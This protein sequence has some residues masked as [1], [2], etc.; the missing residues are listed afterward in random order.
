M[1]EDMARKDIDIAGQ[2]E[3]AVAAEKKAVLWKEKCEAKEA[4]C[5]LP[6]DANLS[7]EHTG[8]VQ[9]EKIARMTKNVKDV[10]AERNKQ[11]QRITDLQK[12][13]AELKKKIKEDNLSRK[14]E[15]ALDE[16]ALKA[17][18]E[19]SDAERKV[20]QE[21]RMSRER[22]Y[23]EDM[24]AKSKEHEEK[25]QENRQEIESLKMYIEDKET[26][27]AVKAADIVNC[28]IGEVDAWEEDFIEKERAFRRERIYFNM[29]L[30]REVELAWSC[31]ADAV[32]IHL[33]EICDKIWTAHPRINDWCSDM[34]S[35]LGVT[36]WER[37]FVLKLKM[38][39]LFS[40]VWE[41]QDHLHVS[42]PSL[43]EAQIAVAMKIIEECRSFYFG[44]QQ[45]F[46]DDFSKVDVAKNG[47]GLLQKVGDSADVAE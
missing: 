24:K 23:E 37:H 32:P 13:N 39:K 41:V 34:K 3:R 43:S 5:K 35:A 26:M 16:A 19:R 15:K 33:K 14:S 30:R 20:E 46:E 45:K 10:T 22:K 7:L 36:A 12:D 29:E 40:D 9:H 47:G 44:M 25:L 6:R 42:E 8:Q 18:K 27:D 28:N 21:D 11:R 2:T 17:Q 1:E 38:D 4:D 31:K